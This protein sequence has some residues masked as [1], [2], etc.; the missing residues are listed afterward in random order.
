MPVKME[1][2]LKLFFA[3]DTSKTPEGIEKLFA[4]FATGT[5]DER[6]ANL[7]IVC[8]A[9]MEYSFGWEIKKA[10]EANDQAAAIKIYT[11]QLAPLTVQM[12][13]QKQT[14]ETQRQ[15][16]ADMFS[17]VK[18]FLKEE[19]VSNPPQQT[20]VGFNLGKTTKKEKNGLSKYAAAAQKIFEE[21][22]GVPA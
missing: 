15:A 16:I 9:L 6:I 14:I 22:K 12:N 2:Q 3:D 17:L 1:A 19:P 21:E 20:K 4:Q 13:E 10:K 11:D 18:E 7:E 5:S 8:K